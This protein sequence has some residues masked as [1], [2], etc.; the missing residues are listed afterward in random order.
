MNSSKQPPATPSSIYKPGGTMIGTIGNWSG[1]IIHIANDLTKDKLGRWSTLHLQGK[2][3]TIITI[4]SVYQVCKQG[5]NGENTAYLQ[6]Q[7]DLYNSK[8]RYLDPRNE[9]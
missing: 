1:R 8:G 9:L 2:N 3:S 5:Y 6:Q 7:A 4:L